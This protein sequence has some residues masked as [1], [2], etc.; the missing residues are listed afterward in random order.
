MAILGDIKTVENID[1]T[2]SLG[3]VVSIGPKPAECLKLVKDAGVTAVIGNHEV[4]CLTRKHKKRLLDYNAFFDWQCS[5]L[6][7]E[8]YKYMETCKSEV[9]RN[10]VRFQHFVIDGIIDEKYPDFCHVHDIGNDDKGFIDLLSSYPEKNIFIGHE[11][12]AVTKVYGDK[13]VFCIGSSG[14]VHGDSTFYKL[15]DISD[16]G[17]IVSIK[18]RTVKYDR[19]RLIKDFAKSDY[20]YRQFFAKEFFNIEI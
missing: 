16:D 17:D 18:N 10:G 19:E 11:H 14:C 3:D 1:E 9:I 7:N 4:E 8:D 20:P 13:N 12:H 2:I 15:L 6:S 5:V